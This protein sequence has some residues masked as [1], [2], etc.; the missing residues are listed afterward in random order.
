MK[1]L[2]PIFVCV[3]FLSGLLSVHG[4]GRIYHVNA[5][6]LK[7]CD[8]RSWVTAFNNLQDA[9]DIVE[10]ED[11]IWVAAGIYHPTKIAI[12]NST[13]E[14]EKSFV[15][16]INNVNIYG[17]FPA[18]GNPTMNNRYP[19]VNKTILSGDLDSN[20]E[21]DGRI[22]GK[23]ASHVII[24]LA[25]E[26][27][28]DG[29]TIS[30]GD[31][32]NP[33]RPDI[34]YIGEK[35]IFN[36]YGG[37]I[38]NVY[39]SRLH[40]RN[41][42]VK[43]NRA[44]CGG[45][46]AND[47][48]TSPQLVN[49]LICGNI[50]TNY[51]GGVYNQIANPKHTNVT[52]SG[53]KAD[54]GSGL[55]STGSS[56][57]EFFNTIITGNYAEDDTYYQYTIIQPDYHYYY[58]MVQGENYRNDYVV[59]HPKVDPN[60]VFRNWVSPGDE[61]SNYDDYRLAAGSIAI[62]AGNNDYMEELVDL[63]G[64]PRT[65]NGVVDIGA[66]EDYNKTSILVSVEGLKQDEIYD[67]TKLKILLYRTDGV[68]IDKEIDQDMIDDLYP[69]EYMI[70]ASYPGYIMSY[71]NSEIK[72]APTWKDATPIH[73][74][75]SDL[76]DRIITIIVTLIPEQEIGDPGVVTVSGTIGF[77]DDENYISG[78]S[79]VRPL[80]NVNGNVNL[81]KSNVAKSD[82]EWVL[83]KTIH[84]TNGQYA[85]NNLG[86]GFY[87]ITADIAGYNP[88]S[89]EFTIAGSNKT[90][91][92]IVDQSKRTITAEPETVTE[93]PF[94][95]SENIKVF[96]NPVIDVLHIS[97]LEGIY[98][99]KI[100]NILGQILYATNGSSPEWRLNIGHLPSGMYFI[101]IE[102]NQKSIIYKII[103]Q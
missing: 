19:A 85:F 4:Q 38:Q 103:K 49:V 22:V 92:F 81:S 12:D 72:H 33:D 94:L 60:M 83:I 5:E 32:T 44:R 9:L 71:H 102:S 17:G 42:I 96:P 30:G 95:Q 2:L 98:S 84:T 18:T 28:L 91:N 45:G 16:N 97:G 80:T 76:P 8:G 73:I 48:S 1:H 61:P 65:L 3:S 46:I 37:G 57:Q 99:V 7:G 50:A 79:K 54:T 53:N 68:L 90:F 67:A 31:A 6:N 24:N 13:D 82:D 62:D 77:P 20:D 100:L 14:R 21:P 58:S 43:A 59:D 25:R 35:A 41:S 66:I 39:L 88:G 64:R 86:E 15:L 26:V 69:G 34:S 74:G 78:L 75:A 29:F 10:P 47:V 63:F 23:N 27:L 87:R 40:L 11:E 52:I 70:S 36:T 56:L 55:Y 89:I 51:G 101:R 93:L